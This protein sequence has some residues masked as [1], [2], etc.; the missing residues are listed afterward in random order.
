MDGAYYKSFFQD[1]HGNES[2]YS[3]A[4]RIV[5]DRISTLSHLDDHDVLG[6]T[7]NPTKL[8][9]DLIEAMEFLK[10]HSTN[11]PRDNQ[12]IMQIKEGVRNFLE[13]AKKKITEKNIFPE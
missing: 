2:K 11:D 8:R 10:R 4:I 7:P 13:E 1:D 5:N 6:D 12:K 9:D 3:Q